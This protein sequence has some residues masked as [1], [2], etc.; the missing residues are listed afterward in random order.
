MQLKPSAGDGAFLIPMIRRLLDS[1]ENT[2]DARR[3]SGCLHAYEL[4]EESAARAIDLAVAELVGRGVDTKTAKKIAHGWVTVGDYL[5]ESRADRKADLVVGN[6]HTSAMTIFRKARSMHTVAS[7][8][9]WSVAA[10][11]M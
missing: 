8:Q 7:T 10:T 5:L 11:Y 6:P 3:N 4:D 1:V 9:Q 2:Q